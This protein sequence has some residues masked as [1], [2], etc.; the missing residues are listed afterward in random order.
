MKLTH[1]QIKS[2]TVGAA[3]IELVDDKTVFHRFTKEQEE[4]YKTVKK[5]FYNKAFSNSCIRLE[6][7]T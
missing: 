5:E 2:I 1:E 6:F 4:L 3:Y 7:E